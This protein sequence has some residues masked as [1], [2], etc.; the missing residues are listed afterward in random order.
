MYVTEL[1]AADTVNTMPEK[2]LEAVAARGELRGDTV[3]GSY[4][5]SR[6]VMRQLADAGTSYEQVVADLEEDGLAKFQVSWDEL[7]ATV[8][9]EL[10]SQAGSP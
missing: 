8:R 6:E 10:A 7:V 1:V 3:R 2:T 5:D 9:T 4:E